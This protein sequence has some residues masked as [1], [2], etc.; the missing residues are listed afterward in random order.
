MQ[1]LKRLNITAIIAI[2][3]GVFLTASAQ[4]YNLPKAH[5][6]EHRDLIAS[7][8]NINNRIKVEHTQQ[9][10]DNLFK[11]EEEPELDIY[12]E[13]WNSKLVNAYANAVIPQSKVIDVSNFCMPHAGYV[14]S[15]YGYRRRFRRMH[16]G[17]DLKVHIGDTIRAAFD[18]KVRLTNFERRGYGNYVIV[19]HTNG[20]E[21]V[22]GH[23]SAFLVEPDEYVKAGDP[24]A[25]GGNTGRSTGPHLHFETRFM[26]MPINP[27]A[28]F[29][30]ANQTVHTDTY[31]FDKNTYQNPRNF[32]PA[33]NSA[34]AKT[35][36]AEYQ[37]T[38]PN[39][40]KNTYSPKSSKS[41]T[42]RKGDSLSRIA[43][44]NGVTVKQLCRLNGLTTASKLRPGQKL[45]L[46]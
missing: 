31:T 38:H 36:M 41:Y 45:R 3:A 25:L 42:V 30:F 32:D 28:I 35:Y 34:Y 27:A 2:T 4:T 17:I 29:D 16:K 8:E 14:T 43:S 22:Y 21:T 26:G 10:I 15:P 7:Q 33:A 19:R 20:L 18:G 37:K 40:A 24:I 23:L 13:G 12:T 46:R 44:R 39:A 11:E 1:L 9:F 6:A 5:T